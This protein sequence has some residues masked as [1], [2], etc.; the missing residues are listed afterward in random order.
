[1]YCRSLLVLA[2]SLLAGCSLMD[3]RKDTAEGAETVRKGPT[4]AVRFNATNFS[5]A[6]G[7]MDRLMVTHQIRDA[8]FVIEDLADNTGKVKAG[9]RDMVISA[10]AEMTRRSRAIKLNA[11]GTDTGNIIGLLERAQLRNA[12]AVVPQFDLRGSVTQL[13]DVAKAQADIGMFVDPKFGLGYSKSSNASI[14]ALD[15][16]VVDTGTLNVIPGIVSKNTVVIFKDG[17]GLDSEA[18]YKKL[19]VNFS[20]NFSLSDGQGQALRNLIELGTVELMGRLF[21]LPYWSCL[22]IDPSTPDVVREVEDWYVATEAHGELPAFVKN[23]LRLR[24][25]YLGAIDDNMDEAT[26]RAVASFKRS[27]GLSASP[28]LDYELFKRLL[29]VPATKAAANQAAPAAATPVKQLGIEIDLSTP[30]GKLSKGGLFE[31]VVRNSTDA[32]VYC[33][34]QDDSGAI[35]RFYPNRFARDSFLSGGAAL[36]LPGKL[37]FKF[38]ASKK[39]VTERIACYATEQDVLAQVEPLRRL[40]DFEPI[41]VTSLKE[42][43]S[44]FRQASQQ[45]FAQNEIAIRGQ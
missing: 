2:L 33:F 43:G 37:P 15:L 34:Y 28:D 38:H 30:S 26:Q 5:E 18:T 40:Q 10:V 9:T 13:D 44:S 25:Y 23:R 45:R 24:G 42:I 17:K 39:G 20:M 32:H 12:Y 8:S 16:S 1:M 4:Q 11:Y 27:Q 14:L 7:C 36:R 41:K 29:Y 31:I 21:K 22:K 35:Q 19:G 3:T 6:L